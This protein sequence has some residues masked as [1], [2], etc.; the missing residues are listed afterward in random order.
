MDKGRR[1]LFE[2]E[3]LA[4]RVMEFYNTTA[5]RDS[6]VTWNFFK[7]EG[8]PSSNVYSYIKKFKDSENVQFKKPAGRPAKL[9]TTRV[10]NRIE[11]IFK[12]KPSTSVAV[13]ARKVKI[14]KSY[15]GEIKVHKLGIKARTKKPAPNYKPV[16]ESRI[17]DCCQKLLKK[18][19]GKVV[20]L[21]D[22]TYVPVDPSNLPG[23]HF[24]HSSDPSEVA[25]EEK[26][27][28]KDKFPKKYCIWQCISSH[29]HVSDPVVLEG[30]I[31]QDI[32]LKNC[33]KAGLE[34]FINRFHKND[35]VLFWPDLAT[36]HYAK[37][38]T[39]YLRKKNIDFV[40]KYINPPNVPQLRPIEKFW[41]RSK[42][43]YSRLQDVPDTFRKFKGRWKKITSEVAKTSGKNLM[44]NLRKK[45]ELVANGGVAAL[46]IN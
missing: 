46:A 11:K 2:R 45:I 29:G 30:N 1:S 5:N 27:R 9:A 15:L 35:K 33:V 39:E 18:M 28:K 21:D 41:A 19:R 31:N 36:C 26:V 7:Q 16:Q 42:S 22:E 4:K 37:K 20:I 32:Y 3:L 40:P 44:K 14:S 25:Y 10:K 17:K 24:F 13:A 38:V 23:R 43:V 12:T 6:K 34:A 8:I